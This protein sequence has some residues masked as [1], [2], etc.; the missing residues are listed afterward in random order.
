MTEGPFVKKVTEKTEAEDGKGK[1][2][3]G[4][5]RVAI[6]EAGKDLVVI[7][8]PG[9]DAENSD[10]LYYFLDNY[11]KTGSEKYTHFQNVGLNAMV[12]AETVSW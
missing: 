5:E 4:S 8:L 9:N 11:L 3:T 7:F 1:S 6:E 10:Q 12:R 2:I